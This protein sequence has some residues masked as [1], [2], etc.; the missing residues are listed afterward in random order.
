DL[1]QINLIRCDSTYVI[2]IYINGISPDSFPTVPVPQEFGRFTEIQFYKFKD[3]NIISAD[4]NNSRYILNDFYGKN[5]L[6]TKIKDDVLTGRFEGF[7][8]SPG[9]KVLNVSEG[10]FQIKIF[11]KHMVY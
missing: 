4:T 1:K 9:G 10:E 6:I 7:L 8:K 11:R 2:A 3:W 5:V